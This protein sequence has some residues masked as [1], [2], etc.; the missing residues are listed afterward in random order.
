MRNERVLSFSAGLRYEKGM[1]N[2]ELIKGL[3][4]HVPGENV[5]LRQQSFLAGLVLGLVIGL[6][7][8]TGLVGTTGFTG[9][10]T[11]A[12]D[13]PLLSWPDTLHLEQ[14]ATLDGP[15]ALAM[16]PSGTVYAATADGIVALIDRNG[17]GRFDR[18]YHLADL[19]ATGIAFLGEALYVATADG[20]ILFFPRI[21]RSLLHP[22][23]PQLLLDG[24]PPLGVLTASTE[25]LYVAVPARCEACKPA[26]RLQATILR[27]TPAV[28][29]AGYEIFA[30]GVK[31]PGGLYWEAGGLWFT[32]DGSDV[33]DAPDELNYAARKGQH[34]GFPYCTADRPD[35]R[36][37]KGL[38]CQTF[39]PPVQLLDV[40]AR[41]A[42]VTRARLDTERLVVAEAGQWDRYGYQLV[43]VDDDL[44]PLIT[45]W[46]Q[47]GHAWGSPT[48][49]LTLPDGSL[50]IADEGSG[51]LFRVTGSTH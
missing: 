29:P 9:F 19:D 17:D 44:H 35:P 18:R 43:S 16:G 10:V 38:G 31:N 21:E 32:D 24:L 4:L 40:N 45:G 15:H 50:L 51:A 33:L 27:V 22:P 11:Y 20:R 5:V 49:L 34:F 46:L 7:L 3:W 14:V 2:E 26:N 13:T 30:S 28:S 6:A 39:E 8:W 48:A 47:D 1:K 25:D 41:A 12:P 42:G 23:S 37:N 36:A